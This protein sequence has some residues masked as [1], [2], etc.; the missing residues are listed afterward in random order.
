MAAT[1]EDDDVRPW[2]GRGRIRLDAEPH[3]AALVERLGLASLLLG[4]LSFLGGAAGIPGLPLGITALVM[5]HRDL[6]K[7][8]AGTMDRRGEARTR[9]GG[10]AGLVGLLLSLLGAVGWAVFFLDRY[11]P[12]PWGRGL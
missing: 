12:P 4:V 1:Y 5:A 9:R 6:A 3:R 2:E 11:L 7:I 10:D 8:R